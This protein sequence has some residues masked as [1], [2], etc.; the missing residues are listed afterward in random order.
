MTS[1]MRSATREMKKNM[2][3]CGVVYVWRRGDDGRSLLGGNSD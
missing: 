2:V 3:E 1:K